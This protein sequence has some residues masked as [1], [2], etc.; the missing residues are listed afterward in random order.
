M[1]SQRSVIEVAPATVVIH[2]GRGSSDNPLSEISVV[3]LA[4]TIPM[5]QRPS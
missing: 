3:G 1:N 4:N 2:S 5:S